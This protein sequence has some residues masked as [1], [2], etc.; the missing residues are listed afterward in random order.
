MAFRQIVV[1]LDRPD[2]CG[3]CLG[4]ELGGP[5]IEMGEPLKDLSEAGV[6]FRKVRV[7]FDRVLEEL[8][9]SK[10]VLSGRRN[11]SEVDST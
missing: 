3:M 2:R 10:E 5:E 11:T 6:R 8:L 1:Q 7:T 4:S 9:S